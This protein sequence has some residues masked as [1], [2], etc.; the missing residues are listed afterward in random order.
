MRNGLRKSL[1]AIRVMRNKGGKKLI[2][3]FNIEYLTPTQKLECKGLTLFT[4][5]LFTSTDEV[6][7]VADSLSKNSYG[8]YLRS[9]MG[10]I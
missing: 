1:G 6:M 9:L 7:R 10:S 4:L 8:C 2:K 5:P 3:Q